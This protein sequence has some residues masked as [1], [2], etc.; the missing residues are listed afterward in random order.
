[1]KYMGNNTKAKLN[2]I[3]VLNSKALIDSYIG[4]DGF[5][6]IKNVLKEYDEIKKKTEIL[7]KNM[8]G[9]IKKQ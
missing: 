6:S 4:Q 2:S 7:A 8:F 3:E 9:V 1:M 5:I